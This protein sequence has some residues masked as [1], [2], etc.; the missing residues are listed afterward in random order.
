MKLSRLWGFSW[1]MVVPLLTALFVWGYRTAEMYRELGLRN[2]GDERLGGMTL[3]NAGVLQ[4]RYLKQSLQVAV[5]RAIGTDEDNGLPRVH[6]FVQ[7]ADI[8]KLDAERPLSGKQY[9]SAR[10]YNDNKF[11]RVNARYRGDFAVHWGFFKRSWRIKTKRQDLFMGARKLNLITPKTAFIYSNHVGYEMAHLIGLLAPKST[12]VNLNINGTH[13]GIY[14][15]VEQITE[16]TL[17]NAGRLPGDIYSGDEHYGLDIWHGIDLPMFESPG[18]WQ[19]VAFNNHYPETHNVPLKALLTALKSDDQQALLN[20]IDADAFA[21]LHLWEHLAQSQHIDDQHNWRLYYDPGRSRFFPILWDGLPWA[22]HW[23]TKEWR[24]DWQ[25][26]KEILVSSLMRALHRN[27]RFLAVKN[28]VFREFLDSDKPNQL[29]ASI[30]EQNAKMKQDTLMDTAIL[31]AKHHWVT[32]EQSLERMADNVEIVQRIISKLKLQLTEPASDDDPLPVVHWQGDIRI[33]QDT[34]ITNPL[35]IAAGSRITLGDGVSLFIRNRLLIDGSE[36][37]PVIFTADQGRFGTVVLEGQ[38][39]NGSKLNGLTMSGGSGYKDD[40]REYSA[41]LSIHDVNG[42]ELTNCTLSNNANYDDQ[43][44]IVYSDIVIERCHFSG[45]PMDAVDLD[46]SKA[47]IS[48]TKFE[49]NGNDGLDLM[50][51][52]VVADNLRF[53]ANG[54]KGISVGERSQLDIEDS[55]FTAN[56]IAIQV[57]DDSLVSG[58]RLSLT[59]NVTALHAYAKNWRY[60]A[61]GFGVFCDMDFGHAKTVTADKSSRLRVDAERCPILPEATADTIAQ[62]KK[63]LK[64]Q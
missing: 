42:V 58:R 62:L 40:L 49:N 39:A 15:L 13:Q 33:T 32:P 16:S 36:T 4:L 44:H 11:M 26:Q 59:S 61:G 22:E 34:I 20:L 25:P 41:M 48:D 38:L 56:E 6:L 18:L 31:S 57:K 2:L 14:L 30:R 50:G 10:L 63:N 7:E 19:K 53:F 12:M 47:V 46:M 17:R 37:K 9:V 27:D 60:G 28:N 54:D 45:A 55:T 23:I 1:L 24:E 8:A 3:H 21:R 35:T 51:T 52:V 43:L 64:K 5:L 29:L